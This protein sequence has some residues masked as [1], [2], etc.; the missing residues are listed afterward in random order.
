MDLKST[1]VPRV[2]RSEEPHTLRESMNFSVYPQTRTSLERR[3]AHAQAKSLFA[4]QRPAPAGVQVLFP[5]ALLFALSE[6]GYSTDRFGNGQTLGENNHPVHSRQGHFN[7]RWNPFNNE[8]RILGSIL[9]PFNFIKHEVGR[10]LTHFSPVTTT[11]LAKASCRGK[12][13]IDSPNLSRQLT[14]Q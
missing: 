5:P 13:M 10:I 4:T 3:T 7:Y 14:R 9:V 1:Y 12:E 11:V 2:S 8:I 6:H